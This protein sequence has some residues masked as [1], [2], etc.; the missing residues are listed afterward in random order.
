MLRA[1]LGAGVN[2][3]ACYAGLFSGA[4][5]ILEAGNK[6]KLRGDEEKVKCEKDSGDE[7]GKTFKR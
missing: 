3:R 1:G 4:A 7:G 6:H 2:W 5:F